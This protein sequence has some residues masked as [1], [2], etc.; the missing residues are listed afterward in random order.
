MSCHL[1]SLDMLRGLHLLAR[2]ARRYLRVTPK[3]MLFF[4]EDFL[5][6]NTL[7]PLKDPHF[8]CDNLCIV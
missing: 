8:L 6:L 3:S 1:L 5:F 2:Q 7:R 4:F